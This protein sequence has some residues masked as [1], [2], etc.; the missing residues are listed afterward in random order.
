MS[1]MERRQKVLIIDDDPGIQ[2]AFRL[3]FDHAG[4]DIDIYGDGEA[5][6]NNNNYPLPDLFILDKQLSGIDGLEVC[7]HLKLQ[8]R[9]RHIPIIILSASPQ[10]DKLATAAGADDFK[11]KPLRMHNLLARVHRLLAPH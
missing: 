2:D 8:R 3:I 5:V 6:L 4:Y 11:E 1:N 9:S 10:L 7:R